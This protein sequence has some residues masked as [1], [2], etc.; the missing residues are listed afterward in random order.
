MVAIPKVRNKAMSLGIFMVV[1]WGF[2][3]DFKDVSILCL[4]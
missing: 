2:G 4:C 1:D 3:Y